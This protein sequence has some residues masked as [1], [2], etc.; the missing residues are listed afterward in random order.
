M[1]YSGIDL[2]SRFVKIVIYDPED[3]KFIKKVKYDTV[4]FYKNF[5][6][7]KN[8]KLI[9]NFDK[10]NLT[11]SKICSTGYGRN[12]INVKNAEIINEIK[13]HF[14]GVIF[15]YNHLKN[16]TILDV[17]GQDTKVIKV[18]DG[19]IED[20]IMNDK[21]AAST[22]RYIENMAKILNVSLEYLSKQIKSPVILNSTCAVFG[23]SEV[24]G[25]IAEGKK[26]SSICAGINLSL[27]KRIVPLINKLYSEILVVSGG[28][29]KNQGLIHF[30][31]KLLSFKE[32]II[33]K[34]PEFNG[35]VGCV[36][37]LILKETLS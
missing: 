19:Y 1:K 22:G 4:F 34:E 10:L 13:A 18:K 26:I 25:K 16:F 8:R 20:F 37:N 6:S 5:A 33:L 12:N 7:I 28:V 31:K 3:K 2:G 24:I 14:F 27:A 36:Y 35:A 11:Y 17:G 9:V 23:E 32:V 29:A 15:H 30:I 21:C